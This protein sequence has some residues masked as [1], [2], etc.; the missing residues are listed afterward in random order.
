M[1]LNPAQ[2]VISAQVWVC[3]ACGGKDNKSCSCSNS[4]ARAEEIA[5]KKESHRQSNRRSYEKN[6]QNQHSSDNPTDVEN[7][8]ESDNARASTYDSEKYHARR[9]AKIAEDN[10]YNAFLM[11]CHASAA[12]ATYSGRIDEK[13]I[14]ACRKVASAW[15][16]MLTQMESLYDKQKAA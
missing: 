2:I 12:L 10:N 5:A 7:I 11:N 16:N 8:E 9:D 6:K 15:S 14:A 3:D 1:Q 13:T 4:T